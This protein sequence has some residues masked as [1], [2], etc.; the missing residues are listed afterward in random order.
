[1]KERYF[2]K[3]WLTEAGHA[4]SFVMCFYDPNCVNTAYRAFIRIADCERSIAI[5][6]DPSNNKKRVAK[7]LID[8]IDKVV[9][10]IDGKHRSR[11]FRYRADSSFFTRIQL[12]NVNEGTAFLDIKKSHLYYDESHKRR[13]LDSDGIRLHYDYFTCD[14]STW[15]CKLGVLRGELLAFKVFLQRFQK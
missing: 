9:S 13:V 2:S 11:R 14:Y 12:E 6:I 10:V 1:M 8:F 15:L 7:K 3:Q 5:A 4:S